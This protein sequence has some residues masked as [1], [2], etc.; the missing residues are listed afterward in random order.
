MDV[1]GEHTIGVLFGTNPCHDGE[2]RNCE[3]E[4]VT[5]YRINRFGLQIR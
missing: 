1:V 3:Y 4:I 5:T 2:V